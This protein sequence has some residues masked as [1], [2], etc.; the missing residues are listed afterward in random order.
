[1]NR[2]EETLRR[3]GSFLLCLILMISL[4]PVS[5][6][7][8]ESEQ[9]VVRVGWYEDAYNI[10]GKN[11]ERSGYGY[12]YEQSVA[13][14]TGWKYEYV[15]AGW[16]DLL[17]MM[18]N[19]EID[20]MGGISYTED[21]AKDMLFSELPM[22]RE[23]YYL[24]AD[25]K[26][27]DI[28][29]SN[30]STLNGKRVALMPTSV[31]ATQFYEWETSHDLHLQYVDVNSF[32]QGKQ[33]A[34]NQEI[35]C[36]VST[37]T[38]DWVEFGMSAIATTGGSDIYFAISKNRPDLKEELDNAM[39]KMEYD[40][41]FYADELYQ[42]YLSAVSLPVI[43]SE[44]ES[45]LNTHGRIK[46]GFLCND[47]GISSY[48]P[49]TGNLAGVLIDYIKF[50]T[51]CLD[52]YTLKF[53][54][55][56]YGSMEEEIQ[57]LKDGEIDFI[58]HFT[59]N[60]YIAEQNDFVL[61]NTVLSYNMAAVTSQTYFNETAENSVAVTKDNL[62]I[63]WYISYNY[64]DWNILEYDSEQEVENA[65]RNG[66]ADCLIADSGKLTK[67]NEDK[68]LHGVFLMQ[69]GNTSFAVNRGN[70]VLMSILNKTLRTLPSS[71]L[72]GA[73]STYETSM[74]KVTLMD[75][76]KDNLAV[77]AVMVGSVFLVVLLIILGF[78]RKS[79][80]AEA[81]AKQAAKESKELNWKLQQSQHELQ[82]ALQAA[83]TASKA[84]TD[85]LSSMSHDI[86]TPMNAIVGLTSL[87]ENDLDDP[88][89]LN[90]Y[91]GKLKSSSKH[92][93]DLINE[94][95]D[96]N[97]IESGKATLNVKPFSMAEQVSQVDNVIRPQA[98]ARKQ[99]F[100]IQTHNIRHENVE[101]DATR[102]QQV[103]LNILS[104]AVKYTQEGG[105]IEL[106]IEE[107]PRDGHYARYKFT[108]TDNGMG[109][110]EEFQKH[111]YESFTRAESSVTNKVQGTGLG[112]A[113]TK[114]IVNIMGGA[115]SLES[116]LGKGSKFEVM[117]EFRIDQEA[118]DAVKQM[119][120][121]LLR[122]SDESFARI[123][124][125]TEN[126]PVSIRRT[127]GPE[128]TENLLRNDHYDVVLVPYLIYG[129]ELD[130]AVQ[131]LRR[132]AGSK[133]ILLGIAAV[134]RDEAIDAVLDSGLDGFVPLPFFLSNLEAE[135]EDVRE[136][137]SQKSKAEE[138][139]VLVGMN[140]L[141]AEDNPLNAEI[142][143]AMLEMQGAA[144]TVCHNGKEIVEKFKAVQP[145]EYDAILMDIQMPV[146]DGYEAT[147]II[148]SGE[149]PLGKT[150]PIIAMT[151]NAFAEDVQKS[152]EAGMD[153]HLS[154]PVDMAVLEQTLRKFRRT[155]PPKR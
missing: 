24:Y 131:K 145:G 22:G 125:A 12:E 139:S 69:P 3:Y 23:K 124:D 43:S 154:K 121:L 39:R 29:A 106:D 1:M 72:T 35:D 70:S 33:L 110:S 58:F 53:D 99:T 135:V 59:Q 60:P 116:E 13:A 95:L 76:V 118:D 101:G 78:L 15:K 122:C 31:Q 134:P 82:A 113:I 137:R 143:E 153:S 9:K 68:K 109:M 65:V 19:G 56:G 126:R 14:Y 128:E 117:L 74:Q 38:P 55:V 18:K 42:R 40:K 105:H 81:K 80:E 90:D 96:M 127:T 97:K 47:I 64:P 87:M 50:A 17:E 93:L 51:D 26:H 44:E 107:L 75:F 148:R 129:D 98:R 141:C 112:M 37:E 34:E 21:R 89:K 66:Q 130:S 94:I 144:C 63:K 67:Y 36:A 133:T 152:I 62:L 46:I 88:K 54:V 151:A 71:M 123:K 102:L 120:L 77:V 20:L 132:L 92:L 147:R 83:E 2:I 61:S 28:S 155:P 7:A 45:W 140:F 85:F 11:G 27:T 104:N 146:M 91:L 52:N 149:N 57:A 48:S 111:I 142:L 119:T 25:L 30:L 4:T 136:H 8:A 5:A 150:I 138:T 6:K 41:P 108:V 16:A 86:R 32:E 115:I 103:L 49:E 84:K 79:L 100:T 10:T 73:L 114:S